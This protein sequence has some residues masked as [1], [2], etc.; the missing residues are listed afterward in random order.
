MYI[1]DWRPLLC[2]ENPFFVI[3]IVDRSRLLHNFMFDNGA[4]IIKES[5]LQE[6]K[7]RHY[8]VTTKSHQSASCYLGHTDYCNQNEKLNQLS[9]MSIAVLPKKIPIPII[10]L[11]SWTNP[12]CK[13]RRGDLFLR[14]YKKFQINTL[15]FL[16]SLLTTIIRPSATRGLVCNPIAR[17]GATSRTRFV[18]TRLEVRWASS[19][20][21][22]DEEKDLYR[23]ASLYRLAHAALPKCENRETIFG[24][25]SIYRMGSSASRGAWI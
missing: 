11:Q 18:A 20:Y 19:W 23:T 1:C 25:K 2:I 21:E 5:A 14:N 8:L 3:H 22:A 15:T 10:L 12:P 7:R 16:S 6:E 24:R 9:R 13:R 17:R 4:W